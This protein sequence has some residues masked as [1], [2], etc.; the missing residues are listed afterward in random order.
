MPSF[1]ASIGSCYAVRLGTVSADTISFTLEN[2]SDCPVLFPDPSTGRTLTVTN[3]M[4]ATLPYLEGRLIKTQDGQVL[5]Q[6]KKQTYE[7][8]IDFVGSFTITSG[9]G[10]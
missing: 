5:E 8:P 6:P 4:S 3:Q 7:V 9:S 1:Q 2:V 10:R